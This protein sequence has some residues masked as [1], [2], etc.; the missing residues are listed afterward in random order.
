MRVAILGGPG[1]GKGTQ[2]KILAQRY[3]VPQI[4]TGDLLREALKNDEVLNEETKQAMAEGRLVDDQ[5]VLKLLE[6][7]LRKRDAKRGFIIDGYPRN[8]PQ[9]QALDTLLGMLG[10]T[11]QIAIN[12]DVDDNALV[13][14]IIGRM[15]CDKCGAIYNKHFSPPAVKNKCDKCGGVLAS[16]VDDTAKTARVRIGVYHAETMPLITYY[17]AQHKLRTMP[18]AGEVDEIHQK[19]CEIVDLEIRPLEIKTLETAADT[20]DEMDATII[21]GGQINRVGLEATANQASPKKRTAT[22]ATIKGAAATQASKKTARKK[23]A[24]K[25]A[26]GKTLSEKKVT[27]KKSKTAKKTTRKKKAASK[28]ISKAVTRKKPISKKN[29]AA[30]IVTKPAATKVAKKTSKKSTRKPVS[31]KPSQKNQ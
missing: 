3:R 25:K 11:L 2:A 8:I 30:A 7:R 14:R 23:I 18:G 9:A 1:S 31:R 24:R 10:K 13:K 29:K 20:N 27:A 28:S 26:A 12:I 4:S 19:L 22:R 6:E 17:R 21:A 5:V 16:R 15:G